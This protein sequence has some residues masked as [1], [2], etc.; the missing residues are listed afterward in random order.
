MTFH[1]CGRIC[2]FIDA[3]LKWYSEFLSKF[4]CLIVLAFERVHNAELKYHSCKIHGQWY[5]VQISASVSFFMN[6][7]QFDFSLS[8]SFLSGFDQH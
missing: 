8:F 1:Q 7:N 5:L 3:K 2:L 4:G 6:Q